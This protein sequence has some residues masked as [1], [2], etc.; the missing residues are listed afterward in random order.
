MVKCSRNYSQQNEVTIITENEI[1]SLFI[2]WFLGWFRLTGADLLWEKNIVDEINEQTGEVCI[3][4][5]GCRTALRDTVN[6]NENS[7]KIFIVFPTIRTCASS[8][9]NCQLLVQ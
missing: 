7:D 3:A 1:S 8:K 2:D 6:N 5:Q 4:V 9:L